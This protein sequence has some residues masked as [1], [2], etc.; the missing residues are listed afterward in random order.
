MSSKRH[1]LIE[2]L[3][4]LVKSPDK[5]ERFLLRHS[6]LPGPRANLE[7]AFALAEI[8]TNVNVLLRWSRISEEQAGTNEPRTFLPFCAAVCLGRAYSQ[9]RKES[10]LVA[11]KRLANDG[12][13]RIR[14]GAAFGFQIIAEHDIEEVKSM[15]SDWILVSNNREKR[16]M[17]VSLAHPPILDEATAAC[18]LKMTG[19]VLERLERDDDFEILKKGLEF[20]ISVFVAAHPRAGFAFIEHWI[21]RDRLIDR[22]LATNLKKNRLKGK[23]KKEAGDLLRRVQ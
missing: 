4:L 20:T 16:A 21:G 9:T 18:G 19:L 6:H 1:L 12:R 22:V 17:L 23:F 11:L 10:A 3:R 2:K 8:Y 5:L 14:E 15:F 13:W 7:I